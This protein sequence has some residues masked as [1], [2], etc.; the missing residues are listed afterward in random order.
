MTSVRTFMG[1]A[2]LAVAA[3][4]APAQHAIDFGSRA[5]D[6]TRAF[7]THRMDSCE[8]VRRDSGFHV[9][10]HGLRGSASFY[11]SRSRLNIGL[12]TGICDSLLYPRC[13]TRTSYVCHPV[14]CGCGVCR[15]VHRRPVVV[16][17]D[18][19]PVYST[20]YASIVTAPVVTQPVIY[21]PPAVVVQPVQV[22]A[23]QPPA[24]VPVDPTT[25]LEAGK[26]ALR[27]GNADRAVRSL[28][29][30]LRD[31]AHDRDG[32][33][34]RL[35]ALALLSANRADEAALMIRKAYRTDVGLVELPFDPDLL[36]DD[37]RR[38]RALTV[39]A[40]EFAN[41]ERSAE[42]WLMV[43]VLLHAQDRIPLARTVV[44][45]AIEAGLERQIGDPMLDALGR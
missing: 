39:R 12:N 42:A 2:G 24:P 26:D 20:S 10:S 36:G 9:T 38:I 32:D 18:P 21:S 14:G 17:D 19:W 15:P 22:A 44:E 16:C 40:V 27:R 3:A 4:A 41:R 45:R 33:S 30:H 11:G 1:M 31:P 7:T 37:D 29:E 25:P 28:K 23:P 34:Q 6:G 43:A 13:S 8:P 35:L 5:V